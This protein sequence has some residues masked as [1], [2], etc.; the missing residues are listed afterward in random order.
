[1]FTMTRSKLFHWLA[2]TG[3]VTVLLMTIAGTWTDPWLWAYMAVWGGVGLV[4]FLSVDDD[5]IRE[6]FHPPDAGADRIPLRVIRLAAL[7]FLVFGALDVGRWHLLPV[8]PALRIVGLIGMAAASSLIV[9]S[10]R[11]NRFF[12][13]VVRVQND[14]GHHVVTSGP[15]ARIRHPGYAGMI[16]S[17]PCAGLALGSWI[18]VAIGMFCS[19]ML[20]RRVVFEDRFLQTNLEGYRDYAMKVR[21]RLIPGAW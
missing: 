19:A 18:S 17:I 14:R 1:M 4:A 21:S 20:L 6:R 13:A 12:S 15:Y 9:G 11:A 5:L 3:A 10:M 2:I 7:A 8:D 16:I